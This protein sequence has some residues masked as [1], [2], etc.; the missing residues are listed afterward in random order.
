MKNTILRRQGIAVAFLEAVTI[1]VPLIAF[2]V[3]KPYITALSLLIFM[4]GSLVLPRFF[5]WRQQ[6]QTGSSLY[7]PYG[8]GLYGTVL[9]L[10]VAIGVL[11]G[12]LT[13]PLWQTYGWRVLFFALWM[14]GTVAAQTVCSW[15]IAAWQRHVRQYWFSEFVDPLGYALPLP[16]AVLGMFM[17]PGSGEAG[18]TSSLIIGMLGIISF[19]FIAIGIFVMATFAFYFYPRLEEYPK[20]LDRA[21]GIVRI[22]IMT[23]SFLGIHYAFFYGNEIPF[24]LFLYYGLPLT[25][26]N[27]LVFVSP[28]ILESI[29]II[30]SIAVSN[31]VV[32][33]IQSQ[34]KAS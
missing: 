27:P 14:I 15:V 19:G 18:V 11:N 10:I 20:K 21:I 1:P 29:I 28:F 34:R 25:Q 17:F 12:I 7:A 2:A 32:L 9:M 33:A 31:L 6:K 23:V 4:I 13:S 3:D 30:V 16:C 8:S 24:R 22:V 26:N 5:Y